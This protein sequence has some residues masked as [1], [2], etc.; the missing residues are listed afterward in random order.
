M[1]PAGYPRP[2]SRAASIRSV[3]YDDPPDM[4]MDG[5]Q[6]GYVPP[7]GSYHP[8]GSVY[9]DRPTYG[10]PNMPQG[11]QRAGSHFS[12][13][14]HRSARGIPE[15]SG[16]QLSRTYSSGRP[17]RYSREG[18]GETVLVVDDQADIEVR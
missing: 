17:N 18:N 1:Q 9:G 7:P 13:L 4:I 8:E 2:M 15:I 11:F 14:S 12:N 5:P 3:H 10:P 16:A 6:P